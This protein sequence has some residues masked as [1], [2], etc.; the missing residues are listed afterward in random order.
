MKPGRRIAWMILGLSVI[1]VFVGT[2][3]PQPVIVWL[4]TQVPLFALTWDSLDALLPWFN[5]LHIIFYA[6]VAALWCALAPQWSR[7]SIILLG[8]TLGLVS[9]TLQLLAPGRTARVSDV[10]NDLIGLAI[11]LTLVGLIR[12]AWRPGQAPGN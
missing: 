2:V 10:L 4:R 6:W 11:G 5:P 9:E 8:G 3:V 7:W 1:V 12:R